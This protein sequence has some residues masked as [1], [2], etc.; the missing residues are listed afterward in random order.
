MKVQIS[1]RVVDRFPV[2]KA[3][4]SSLSRRKPVY[5]TGVND[6]DYVTQPTI[7]GKRVQCYLYTTWQHML[8]RCY[9]PKYKARQPTYAGCTVAPEW[10]IFSN[11]HGWMIEQDWLGKELDKDIVAA[12][13]KC[14]SP[15]NCLFVS[16]AVN[17]LLN[18]HAA[19]RGK[20]PQGVN[21]HKRNG[22]FR[23]KMTIDG[24]TKHLGLYTTP[25]EA[26][27]VYRAAKKA[28]IERVA[29][30]QTC[31]ITKAGLLRHA[32]LLT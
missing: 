2:F 19:A 25:E 30:L 10:L 24:K 3:N 16:R 5:G 21:Y 4:I 17:S 1:T 9:D 8:K 28:N 14:Y 26:S 23:A 7:D 31:Q 32:A 15:E 6:A 27:T 12:G 18:D 11:F 20:W 22:T 29:H 13:N